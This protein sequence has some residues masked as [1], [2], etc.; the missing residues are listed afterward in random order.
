MSRYDLNGVFRLLQEEGCHNIHV[1]FT[2]GRRHGFP[3]YGVILL[4]QK[5]RS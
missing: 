2:E 1:Q 5:R 3:L 4:F